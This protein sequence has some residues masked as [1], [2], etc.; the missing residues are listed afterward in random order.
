MVRFIKLAVMR[1][2]VKKELS[3][4]EESRMTIFILGKMEGSGCIKGEGAKPA[5]L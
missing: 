1:D 5:V 4:K 2:P 3:L